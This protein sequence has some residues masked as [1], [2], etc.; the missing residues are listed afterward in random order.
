MINVSHT[1]PGKFYRMSR[2]AGFNYYYVRPKLTAEQWF[3]RM[4]KRRMGHKGGEGSHWA[5]YYHD[6]SLILLQ[7]RMR[8]TDPIT[9]KRFELKRYVMMD[10]K[11]QLREVQRPPG[12]K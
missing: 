9:G 5:A 6:R 8:G 10:P 1:E 2:S 11:Y 3:R 7:A 12:Y 4:S